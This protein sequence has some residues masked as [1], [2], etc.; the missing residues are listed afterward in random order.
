MR[1]TCHGG[2][3]RVFLPG[4]FVLS[5]LGVAC[6]AFLCTKDGSSTSWPSSRRH[7]LGW[8][9]SF[10]RTRLQA[11]KDPYEIL[12][13]EAESTEEEIRAAY[14]A[15]A[16]VD[17]PDISDH[18]DADQRWMDICEAYKSLTDPRLQRKRRQESGQVS[19]YRGDERVQDDT[20]LKN[21]LFEALNAMHSDQKT[22][23]E[24]TLD[25]LKK[26][27][28]S[29]RSEAAEVAKAKARA[30]EANLVYSRPPTSSQTSA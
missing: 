16:R 3:R 27:K 6:A 28:L 2:H 5:V 11:L 10:Q 23:L 26:P 8:R 15:R 9:A 14:R 18:P 24:M 13:V 22:A 4:I 20:A 17:H 29:S 19:I 12:G 21:Q 1:S 30:Q 25:D 7:S